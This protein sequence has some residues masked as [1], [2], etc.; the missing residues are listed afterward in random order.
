M[1][2]SKGQ[3]S[4]MEKPGALVPLWGGHGRKRDQLGQECF[5]L[6]F[7]QVLEQDSWLFLTKLKENKSSQALVRY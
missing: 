1:E 3:W 2:P 6:I 4:S 7:S 5:P